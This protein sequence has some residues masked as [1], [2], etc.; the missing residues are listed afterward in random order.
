MWLFVFLLLGVL[1]LP[2]VQV[3]LGD[4][5]FAH[6]LKLGN[7][8]AISG[9]YE[10]D[11]TNGIHYRGLVDPPIRWR[12]LE[13]VARGDEDAVEQFRASVG[14]VLDRP[15][16]EIEAYSSYRFS[17][18]TP[19][20]HISLHEAGYTTH[21][22]PNGDDET[23]RYSFFDNDYQQIGWPSTWVSRNIS[24]WYCFEPE[25]FS[26]EGLR[27]IEGDMVHTQTMKRSIHWKNIL[28]A[29]SLVVFVGWLASRVSTWRGV[30]RRRSHCV[31]VAITGLMVIAMLLAGTNRPQSPSHAVFGQLK[32]S[33][34]ASEQVF[35]REGI[36][37][38]LV[39]D[40]QVQDLAGS[41]L[42]EF[43]EMKVP[44]D[45]VGLGVQCP[46]DYTGETYTYGFRRFRLV[47]FDTLGMTRLEQDG[48]Y[49]GLPL[50]ERDHGWSWRSSN[51]FAWVNRGWGQPRMANYG[52]LIEYQNVFFVVVGLYVF[53]RLMAWGSSAWFWRRQRRRIKRGVCIWCRYPVD[54]A[55][56]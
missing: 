13:L 5:G 54:G 22:G 9:W 26:Q 19:Y 23:L 18:G 1:G 51:G 4:W 27:S 49:S 24:H 56:N 32:S 47:D 37:A 15:S 7:S 33:Q 11:I 40:E 41:M 10:E 16:L 29:S 53:W 35:D 55:G 31:G 36:D 38:F 43:G 45:L 34:I 50:L 8:D 25:R 39:S 28:F 14:R 3:R 42:E 21:D 12:D 46:V 17:T 2:W 20:Q 48:T 30:G 52:V 44:N 6:G